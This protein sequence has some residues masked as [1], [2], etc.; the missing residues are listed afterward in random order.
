MFLYIKR[1][2][3]LKLDSSKVSAEGEDFSINFDN[4]ELNNKYDY[5]VALVRSSIWYIPITILAP[6]LV[7]IVAHGVMG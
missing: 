2:V 4:L 6:S 5:E 1:M 3:L 7:I